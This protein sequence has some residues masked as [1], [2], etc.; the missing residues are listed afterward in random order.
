MCFNWEGAISTLIGGPLKLFDKFTYLGSSVSSTENDVNIV[1]VWT[2]IDRLPIIQKSDLSN[3]MKQNF[4]QA[5][6]VSMWCIHTVLLVLSYYCM[7]ASHERQQNTEKKLDGNG[8]RML[9]AILNKSWK[10]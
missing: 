2:A 4:F 7:D 5:V 9:Q 1:K 10:Q 8:S 3:K 6:A